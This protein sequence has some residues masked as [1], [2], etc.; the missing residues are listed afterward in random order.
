MDSW[1]SETTTP[2]KADE[3]VL[4]STSLGQPADLKFP[5]DFRAREDFPNRNYRKW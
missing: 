3:I 1:D 5:L 2:A 4:A